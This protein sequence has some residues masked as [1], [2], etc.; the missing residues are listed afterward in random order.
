MSE[1]SVRRIYLDHCATTPVSAR[2]L[3]AM[4]PYFGEKFGNA[5]S[6]HRYGQEARAA[7]DDSRSRIARWLGLPPGEIVFT[8]GGTESD[9]HALRGVARAGL[10]SGKR[11]IVTSAA[12]HHAVLDTCASLE[13]EGFGVTRLRVD[14]AGMVSPADVRAAL[15]TGTAIISIMHANNETGTL[16]PAAEIAAIAREAGIPFHCDAIQSFGKISLPSGETAPDLLSISAHK[17]YGPKGVGAV[18]VKRQVSIEKLIHG[19]SHER[20]MRAG[21]ENVPLVVGFAE[22]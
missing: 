22:A 20:G 1:N 3:E 15:T 12:E 6:V 21:T 9:N 7:I 14:G 16:N 4:A 10:K 8:S 5:S 2:V 13:G 19:G 17:I 11:H 18:C